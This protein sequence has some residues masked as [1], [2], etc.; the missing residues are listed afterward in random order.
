MRFR[1]VLLEFSFAFSAIVATS[2]EEKSRR[3]LVVLEVLQQALVGNCAVCA[4]RSP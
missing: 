3:R 1:R 4:R 2:V